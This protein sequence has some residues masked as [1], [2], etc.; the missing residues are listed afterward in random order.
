MRQKVT[1][2]TIL[3]GGLVVLSFF[4]VYGDIKNKAELSKNQYKNL[5]LALI[6]ASQAS[7]NFNSQT[8][9]VLP[10][11]EPTYFPIRNSDIAEPVVSAKS[12]LLYDTKNAKTLISR[13][14]NKQLPI[15]SL[16]KLLTALVALDNL[17]PEDTIE[18]Q[19]ESMNVG[20]EGADFYLKEKFYFQDILKAMLIK[21]SND[22]ASAI[23]RAVEQK[24][25]SNFIELMNQKAIQVGLTNSKFL[26]PAGLN[27]EAYS[28]AQDLLKLVRYSKRFK[29]I[30]SSLGSRNADITSQDKK[31]LHHIIST[32]KLF[33]SLPNIVGG[34]TGYTDGALGC[35]IVEERLDKVGSSLVVI[36]LGSNDRFEDASKIITWAEKAF[37]WNN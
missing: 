29:E 8:G 11:S 6:N 5:N 35:I 19:K 33:N 23:A 36:V 4:I 20:G 22:A 26:D 24:T 21:S 14:A 27:D 9:Y 31:F 1:I 28:T 17:N 13:D 25:G 3:V 30:W 37:R 12:F 7:E 10:I 32:N 16:T 2:L 18:I 34:K 15:A